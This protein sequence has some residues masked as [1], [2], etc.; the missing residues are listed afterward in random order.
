LTLN[1]IYGKI[2]KENYYL[3]GAEMVEKERKKRGRKRKRVGV[4]ELVLGLLKVNAKIL[5]LIYRLLK[6]KEIPKS[7]AENLEKF[8]FLTLEVTEELRVA[9]EK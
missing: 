6:K 2:L 5:K 8:V 7:I 4:E 3:G 9:I 1:K